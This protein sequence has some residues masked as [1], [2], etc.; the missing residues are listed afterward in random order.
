[1][2]PPM[3]MTHLA[4]A[5]LLA[6]TACSDDG[7]GGL[8]DATT[9]ASDADAATSDGRDATSATTTIAPTDAAI[10]TAPDTNVDVDVG[11]PTIGWVVLQF[12]AD[13]T[14]QP[15]QAFGVYGRVYAQ[16]VTD[17][18]GQGAG[19]TA[20]VGIGTGDVATWSWTAASYNVDVDGAND[21]YL[22]NLQLPNSAGEY[23]FAFRFRLGDGA[24][25][26]AD[27]DG[28]DNGFDPTNTGVANVIVPDP[29]AIDWCN[30]QFPAA[31]TSNPGAPVGTIYG[32]VYEPDV[33]NAVAASDPA[34]TIV[35]QLGFGAGDDTSAWTWVD[36]RYGKDVGNNDEFEGTFEAPAIGTYHYAYRF[37]FVAEAQAWVYC[38][39]TGLGDGFAVADSGTL[40]VVAPPEKRIDFATLRPKSPSWA[41]SEPAPT[42]E[43]VTYEAG[44]TD[45]AGQGAGIVVELGYGAADADAA[46]MTWIATTYG[47]D[48]DG[49]GTNDN[50][51]YG[52]VLPST[53]TAGS[54]RVIARVT[55]ADGEPVLV[56]TSGTADGFAI[57]DAAVATITP[58]TP[59]IPDFCRLNAP[60]LT[61]AAPGA[62]VSGLQVQAYEAGV[63]PGSTTIKA[64]LGI[65][66]Q[67]GPP[68]TGFTWVAAPFTS[69]TGN[70]DLFSATLTA[71]A[72]E[73]TFA[74]AGRVAIG[75]GPWLYCDDDG[76]SDGYDA[77][78]TSR[79]VVAPPPV[80]YLDY[81]RIQFPT[82]PLVIT[83]SAPDGSDVYGLA[84]EPGVTGESG[85]HTPAIEAQ[86]GYALAGNAPPTGWT[87]VDGTFNGYLDN[88]FGQKSNDEYTAKLKVTTN[89][90]YIWAFRMSIDGGASWLYCDKD[91]NQP[92]DPSRAGTITIV[93]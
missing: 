69:S 77:T 52:A 38:D 75:S 39:L 4:A 73:G 48:E 2:V 5:S 58:A 18:A 6:L 66:P 43:V 92:F 60:E 10:T 42:F 82:D 44:V 67:G 37:R 89:G 84:Y 19:I 51:V 8:K 72:S 83:L 70:D 78:Q 30:L 16:G 24:W 23:R 80:N 56:D 17:G 20:E 55:L 35:A 3:R 64:E 86:A 71:P 41:V 88:G 12:P 50:D 59:P 81:C 65:G 28:S 45:Q 68:E 15:G 29:A 22:G 9:S 7:S 40:T 47:G 85:S 63:T 93:P 49:L 1:M 74:I 33:T 32:Q 13:F 79:L 14:G 25:V 31:L 57:M 76:S 26:Y 61:S 62:P 91:G 53:L 27:R 46:A 54:Y 34:Y 90:D 36:A 11:P 87:W 21:E